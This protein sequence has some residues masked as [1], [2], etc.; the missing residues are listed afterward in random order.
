MLHTQK[1]SVSGTRVPLKF[2]PMKKPMVAAPSM[3]MKPWIEAAVPAMWPRGSM[4]MALRLP[5]RRPKQNIMADCSKAKVSRRVVAGECHGGLGEGDRDET[6]QGSVGE[7][8]HAEALD[9]FC[10]GE[11]GNRHADGAGGED[12]RKEFRD[13]EDLGED[14]LCGVDK[15]EPAAEQQGRG[16]RVAERDAVAQSKAK[17]GGDFGP[18]DAAPVF[19]VLGLRQAPD[20]P[21]GDQGAVTTEA[22]EDRGPGGEEQDE[23]ADGWGEDGGG[24][25]DH[26]A[27][28]VDLRHAPPGI[29]VPDDG[30]GEDLCARSADALGDAGGQ[31]PGEARGTSGG[32]AAEDVEDQ[33]ADQHLAAPETVRH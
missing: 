31:Q 24:E 5:A 8:A 12:Q 26:E 18:G 28:R 30:D 32:E 4:E 29:A 15:T 17:G 25:E 7:R 13:A 14:L 2:W 20:D 16:Q 3:E 9:Q 21:G 11:G 10:V 22:D 27:E 1:P 33:G 6:E 19:F 23:L